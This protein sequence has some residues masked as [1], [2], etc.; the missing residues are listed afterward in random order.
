[1]HDES[2]LFPWLAEQ[3]QRWNE[4]VE[5]VDLAWHQKA[6][7]QQ[8]AQ[9]TLLW[10]RLMPPDERDRQCPDLPR[11]QCFAV[12][13]CCLL[14]ARGSQMLRAFPIE[15][16]QA[17]EEN[18]HVLTSIAG[19]HDQLLAFHQ[20]YDYCQAGDLLILCTDAIG[21]WAIK[22]LEDGATLLWRDFWDMSQED[23]AEYIGRM[24]QDQRMRYDDATMVILRICDPPTGAAAK[25]G[26]II[27]EAKRAIDDVT[28]TISGFFGSITSKKR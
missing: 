4:S 19:K 5:T 26:Q 21:A 23:W 3:R 12:G 11:L 24:R 17:F 1:M 25:S 13:D 18:P 9:S 14:H 27:D 2:S 10:V 22:A 28:E 8:G 7:M 16:S 15:Q 6:K 20:L